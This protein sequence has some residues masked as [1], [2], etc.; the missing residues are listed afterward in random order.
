MP[1]TRPGM[2]NSGTALGASR[3]ISLIRRNLDQT[4]VGIPA[5]DRVQHA[6]GALFLDRTFLD[7]HAVRPEMRGHRLRSAGGEKAQIV[8]AGG[9]V[10]GGVTTDL[11][12]GHWP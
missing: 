3:R 12:G 2:T 10:I 11:V 6:A 4:A 1:G 9:F 8:T 7:R 5:I